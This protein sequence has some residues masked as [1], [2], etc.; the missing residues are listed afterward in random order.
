MGIV[1][2]SIEL[3]IEKKIPINYPRIPRIGIP[4]IE[5]GSNY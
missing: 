2:F 4:R 3:K 1:K 5:L